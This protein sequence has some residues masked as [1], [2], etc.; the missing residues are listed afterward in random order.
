MISLQELDESWYDTTLDD[1]FDR[2]VFLLGEQ[3]P[4][5]SRSIQLACRVIREDTLDHLIRQL[6]KEKKKKQ[7]LA[8]RSR[9][10]VIITGRKDTYVGYDGIASTTSTIFII[11][12]C[13]ASRE[14]VPP[15]GNIFLSLLLPDLHLLIFT[16]TP[17]LISL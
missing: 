9:R 13:T 14:Q 11:G 15:L 12:I 8:L 4:E 10:A 1:L 17:Q 5:F 16:S 3:L 7:R 2:R 6:M